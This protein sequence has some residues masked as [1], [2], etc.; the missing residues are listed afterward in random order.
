VTRSITTSDHN[1]D[2][3]SL[4]VGVDC[5]WYLMATT[6]PGPEPYG[7]GG[8]VEL[9]FSRDNGATWKRER[10]LTSNSRRNHTYPRRPLDLHHD[11][12]VLWADGL[13]R[14]P[15]ESSLYFAN[16]EGTRVR[17]LP[18]KMAEEFARP[19]EIRP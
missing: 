15:S 3:G 9:W 18:E 13:T 5:T 4:Y 8:E 10:A 17:R 1:Y 6:G 11:F 7:T 12:A 19:E 14:K 16:F 2:H